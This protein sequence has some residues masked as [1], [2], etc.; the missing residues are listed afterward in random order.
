MVEGGANNVVA[1]RQQPVMP[2]RGVG[3]GVGRGRGAPG[4]SGNV[5]GGGTGGGGTGGGWTKGEMG[6][7]GSLCF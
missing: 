6:R 2:G 1:R 4:G 3:R 5:G 7:E